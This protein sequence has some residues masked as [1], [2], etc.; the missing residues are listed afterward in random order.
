MFDKKALEEKLQLTEW[1]QEID[2]LRPLAKQKKIE[3]DSLNID[4]GI[5][6]QEI[7]E[8][9]ESSLAKARAQV[10][11]LDDVA[12]EAWE[13][14]ASEILSEAETTVNDLRDRFQSLAESLKDQ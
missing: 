14:R 4:R 5:T 11:S 13:Q 12:P 7:F 9:M 8:A 2:R 6:A 3:E 1:E 10:G